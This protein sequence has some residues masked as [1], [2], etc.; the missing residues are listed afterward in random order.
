MPFNSFNFWLIFPFIFEL[1]WLLLAK[2]KP[3]SD[4]SVNSDLWEKCNLGN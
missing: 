1:Y 4:L 2:Y 3:G